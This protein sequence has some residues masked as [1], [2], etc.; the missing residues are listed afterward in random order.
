MPFG[1]HLVGSGNHAPPFPKGQDTIA[2]GMTWIRERGGSLSECLDGLSPMAAPAFP[3]PRRDFA[4]GAAWTSECE[5]WARSLSRRIREVTRR[6]LDAHRSICGRVRG[7]CG[8]HRCRQNGNVYRPGL[9]P[10]YC[11]WNAGQFRVVLKPHYDPV[12]ASEEEPRSPHFL[13]VDSRKSVER[14][15]MRR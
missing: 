7:A 6:S 11:L 13:S 14:G 9:H 8:D 4:R 12:P 1:I 10:D 15:P 3:R 5:G 2:D